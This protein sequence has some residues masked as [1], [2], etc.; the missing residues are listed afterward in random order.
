MKKFTQYEIYALR[1]DTVAQAKVLLFLKKEF[2]TDKVD[3]YLLD[4]NESVFMVED[5]KMD[6]M[7]FWFDTDTKEVLSSE[8]K[9]KIKSYDLEI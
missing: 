8:R 6:K 2:D 1:V 7:Y 3:I 4:K 9:P 5:E